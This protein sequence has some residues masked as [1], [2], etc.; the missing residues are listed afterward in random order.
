MSLTGGFPTGDPNSVLLLIFYTQNLSTYRAVC[1]QL[2]VTFH[3]EENHSISSTCLLSTTHRIAI[4]TACFVVAVVLNVIRAFLFYY[5]CVNAS[6][7]LHSKMFSAV[8]RTPMRFFDTNPMGQCVI[9]MTSILILTAQC[10]TGRVLNRFSKDVGFLDKLLPFVFC[11]YML[12]RMMLCWKLATCS[13][14]PFFCIFI[15]SLSICY[16]NHHSC[17]VKRVAY[18]PSHCTHR[19]VIVY[20]AVLP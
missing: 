10:I 6:C 13:Q 5:I 16:N 8:L 9:I 17:C 3:I 15:V 20:T 12:V 11:E 2:N 18:S 19:C 1:S 7:V 14:H 4:Y